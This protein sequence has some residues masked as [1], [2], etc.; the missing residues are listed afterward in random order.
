[1]K[2]RILRIMH[3]LSI[4]G[5]THQAACLT[6]ELKDEFDTM[7]ASGIITD[8]EADGV[9]ILDQYQVTPVYIHS[10]KRSIN[11][12]QDVMALYEIYKLIKKYKPDIVHTHAAKSGT[13]GRIAAKLA[14]VPIV[15]HTF[16]GHV[17][18]SY[19]SPLV[20]KIFILVER[21]L[22]K[23]STRIIAISD[24]QKHDLVDRFKICSAKKISVIPL[25]FDLDPFTSITQ[26]DRKSFRNQWSIPDDTIAIGIVGR[27]TKI[28]NHDLFLR[29]FAKLKKQT[30]KKLLAVIIG[31][32]ELRA[33]LEQLC[34]DLQLQTNKTQAQNVDVVFT[35]WQTQMHLVLSGLDIV[36]LTS[37]NEGTP[38][39][40]IEALA[41]KKYVVSSDV[42]GVS[43]VLKTGQNGLLFDSGDMLG[44]TA[45]LL[46]IIEGKM[47]LNLDLIQEDILNRFASKRLVKDIRTLYNQLLKEA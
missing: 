36:A 29:S 38:V 8:G 41:A 43:D 16:H 11:P 1:M 10:L 26:Q 4:S 6:H 22:A 21:F 30:G 7:L 35:S 15:L 42:G 2:P 24:K 27:L 32:G 23:L 25:G 12:F 20:S 39:S 19:F 5:P 40:L 34:T 14:G 37:L 17:F 9:S 33:E 47:Q 18:H 13:L 45:Q 44:C 28:K 46:R 3:R 31:D